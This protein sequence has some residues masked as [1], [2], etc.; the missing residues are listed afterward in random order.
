MDIRAQSIFRNLPVDMRLESVHPECR[1]PQW[2]VAS[3]ALLIAVSFRRQQQSG[4]ILPDCYPN[5]N[6]A[7][8]YRRTGRCP[9]DVT[10]GQATG[11]YLW[12]PLLQPPADLWLGWLAGHRENQRHAL[13]AVPT[14]L[15]GWKHRWTTK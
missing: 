1:K 12:V 3:G 2:L 11:P 13:R 5:R 8:A 10:S 15:S 14:T 4:R 6:D 7:A 9:S